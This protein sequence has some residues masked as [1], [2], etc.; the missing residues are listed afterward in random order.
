MA[1]VLASI[2]T[3]KRHNRS[4]NTPGGVYMPFSLNGK[5]GFLVLKCDCVIT[6]LEEKFCP[7]VKKFLED[8]GRC[9][10]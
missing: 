4:V 3:A 9:K 8:H 5:P 10:D 6:A 7:E 1:H 2:D